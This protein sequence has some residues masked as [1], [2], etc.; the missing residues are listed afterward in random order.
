MSISLSE[1]V[2]TVEDLEADPRAPRTSIAYRA[3]CRDCRG[4]EAAVVMLTA[5]RYEWMIHVRNL[6]RLLNEAEAEIREGRTRPAEEVFKELEAKG[7]LP[8][9][10]QRVRRS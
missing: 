9:R 4:R 7:K 1:D 5:E 8:R 10:K 3:A 6:A 2:K